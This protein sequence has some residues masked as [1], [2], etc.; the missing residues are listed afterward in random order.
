MRKTYPHKNFN[1]EKL[2]NQVSHN[3]ILYILVVYSLTI[4]VWWQ[5]LKLFIKT[6]KDKARDECMQS[7]VAIVRNFHIRKNGWKVCSKLVGFESK[8]P[9]YFYKRTL[10]NYDYDMK[11]FKHIDTY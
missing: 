11:K 10:K 5:K 1:Q 7:L 9:T 6:R 4:M 3:F 8:F 2:Y